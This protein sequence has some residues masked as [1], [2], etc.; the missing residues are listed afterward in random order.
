MKLVHELYGRC[1]VGGGPI[2]PYA[3]K[4]GDSRLPVSG[5]VDELLIVSPA[6]WPHE[7]DSIRID[8]D[9][10]SVYDA[11]TGAINVLQVSIDH[12]IEHGELDPDW[13]EK[14]EKEREERSTALVR[15]RGKGQG[16]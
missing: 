8:G 13:R 10:L 4:I 9:L 15:D 6:L 3:R 7:E 1:Q 14:A 2:R 12:A 11:L 16:R 5:Y